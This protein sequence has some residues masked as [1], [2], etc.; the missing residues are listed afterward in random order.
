MQEQW[1]ILSDFKAEDCFLQTVNK[2]LCIKHCF[3][4][5]NL[6]NLAR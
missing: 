6:L 3:P 2:E 5:L 4:S 1:V